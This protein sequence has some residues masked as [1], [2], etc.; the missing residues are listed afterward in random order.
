IVPKPGGVELDPVGIWTSQM[1]VVTEALSK[2]NLLPS[3]F[4]AIGITNQR[5]TTILW[6]RQTG[7]RLYNAIVW[8]ARRT[9]AFCNQLKEQGLSDMVNSKTGLIID[10]YFSGTKIK[11][12]L[13]N[14]A[15]VREKAER[16]EVCF[17]T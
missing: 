6:D 3:Q 15:G 13:D 2:I 7:K 9:S 1:S 17:G 11:W 4:A 16:G 8:Q 5:E 12:I 14:V 10:A